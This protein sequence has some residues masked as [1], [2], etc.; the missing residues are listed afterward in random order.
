MVKP[1]LTFHQSGVPD[2]HYRGIKQGWID[3][4]WKPLKAMLERDAPKR[5]R[6]A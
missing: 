4:Y 1:R 6:A 2:K 5:S 3:Y